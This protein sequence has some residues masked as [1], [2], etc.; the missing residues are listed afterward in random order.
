VREAIARAV[1]RRLA[2]GDRLTAVMMSGG[3]DSS[4]VA[5]IAAHEAP[6]RIEA[7]SGVFP[8]HPAVDESEL[9]ATLH[10]KLDLGGVSAEIRPGGLLASAVESQRAWQLPLLSWGDF[11]TLPLL[12]AAAER[13]ASV[14]LGGDG[15]DELFDVR[16]F[17]LADRLRRCNAR[18]VLDLARE[19]PGAGERPPRRQLYRAAASLAVSGAL[20]YHLH[21]LLRR[22]FR[23]HGL[24]PWLGRRAVAEIAASDDPL[25]WKRLAGPR[26]WAHAA[27][28]LSRG[29]EAAGVFELHRHRASLAGVEARH[30]LLDLDLVELVLRQPPLGSFD[31][32]LNRPM[33]RA[34]MVGLL[35]D[36][37]RLRAHKALFDSLVADTLARPDAPA[38]RLL[39]DDRRAELGAYVELD[40][41]RDTLLQSS[42]IRTAAPFRWIQQVW[43]LTTAECWLRAQTDPRGEDLLGGLRA[44]SARASRARVRVREHAPKALAEPKVLAQVAA[45]GSQST[46]T[47]A[48]I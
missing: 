13:G 25:A 19:L 40:T 22:P 32:Y 5:A 46:P 39:L 48:R 41:V 36:A 20:P 4:A 33:L 21:E 7:Y 3:L 27:H 16:A 18:G 8:E 12:R 43:R 28:G 17:L 42:S 24:P 44:A 14:V 11:W 10:E 23:A 2:P 38:V 26:W 15:G 34:G 30:P 29:I 37:V 1:R 31:R 9:I 45:G 35:P 6:G 47:A